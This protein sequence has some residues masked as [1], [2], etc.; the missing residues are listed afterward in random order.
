M[1][2]GWVAWFAR[3][4]IHRVFG[5]G[6]GLRTELE[7]CDGPALLLDDTIHIW[8]VSPGER[9]APGAGRLRPRPP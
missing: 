7:R 2:F 5:I 4:W 6:F 8:N 1:E 9:P 3:W